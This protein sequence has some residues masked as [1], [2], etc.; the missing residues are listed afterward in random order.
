MGLDRIVS[1]QPQYSLLW[2]VPETEVIPVSKANGIGQIVWSPL[3]Q[4]VLTGKYLPG[5]PVPEGTRATD[6]QSKH[7]ISWLLRDEVLVPVQQF[8]KLAEEAGHSPAEVALA[9]VL[10]NDGVSSA[11]I[12]A[13]RPEQVV[14]N[15]RAADITLDD[16]LVKA[17]DD[18]L[19]PTV[20]RDPSMTTSPSK[21]P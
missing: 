8:C 14:Q 4:G 11:I 12:G 17:I 2:R 16:D 1:N 19:A 13:S 6:E 3:A 9:W 5:Q 21:R 18:V 7:F 20:L 10:R 15:V